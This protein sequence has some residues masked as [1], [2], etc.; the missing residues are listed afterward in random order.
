MKNQIFGFIFCVLFLEGCTYEPP[1]IIYSFTIINNSNEEISIES[2]AENDE[3][4][5]FEN[6]F[7]GKSYKNEIIKYHCY[8]DYFKDTLISFFFKPFV[9][10]HNGELLK[11]DPM[12]RNNWMEEKYLRGFICKEGMISYTLNVTQKNL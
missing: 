11:I 7:P 8:R 2:K 1:P 9:I 6:I 3:Y 12:N 10:T 5:V 4:P